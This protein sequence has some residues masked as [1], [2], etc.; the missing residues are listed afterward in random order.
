MYTFDVNDMTCGHCVQT[1]ETAVKGVDGAAAVTIDLTDHAVK[2]ASAE[3][4][5]SFADAIK[6]AGYTP[7]LR[8]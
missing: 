1:I 4:A 2:I 3:P 5:S 6:D 7:Q 8:A